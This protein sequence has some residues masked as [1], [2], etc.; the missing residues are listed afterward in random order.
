MQRFE[1]AVG[2]GSF[3]SQLQSATGLMISNVT[4]MQK[5]NITTLTRSALAD[6]DV[7][8]GEDLML[9]ADVCKVHVITAYLT[10]LD[11]A[12]VPEWTSIFIGA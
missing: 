4:L 8:E 10:H 9:Y 11:F 2:D 1:R 3:Q 12:N 6:H 5:P 7:N